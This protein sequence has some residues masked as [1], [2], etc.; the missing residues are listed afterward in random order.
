LK[1]FFEF[2]NARTRFAHNFHNVALIWVKP[3]PI[4]CARIGF[5]I[6]IGF[7]IVKTSSKKQKVKNQG[8]VALRPDNEKTIWEV[9]FGFCL[10]TIYF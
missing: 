2:K 6:G 3:A 7:E 10:C 5:S 9:P 8:W 1:P 4:E